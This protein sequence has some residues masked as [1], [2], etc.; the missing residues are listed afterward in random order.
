MDYGHVGEV[1]KINPD[2]VETLEVQKFIPVIAPIGAGQDGTT[3][4]INADSV[5]GAL[6]GNAGC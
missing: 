2:V 5:A 4:N 6:A 3:Y 1:D